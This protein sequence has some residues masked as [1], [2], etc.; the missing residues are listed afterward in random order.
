MTFGKWDLIPS[1]RYAFPGIEVQPI[2]TLDCP[3]E[4]HQEIN[5]V[6]SRM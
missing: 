3:P 4:G 2:V 5:M 6:H 1:H